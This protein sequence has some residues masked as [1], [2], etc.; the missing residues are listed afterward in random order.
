[1]H[2]AT[3][4]FNGC[5]VLVSAKSNTRALTKSYVSLTW[6][7]VQASRQVSRG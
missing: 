2:P 7:R 1:M 4:H 5:S 6:M 3:H